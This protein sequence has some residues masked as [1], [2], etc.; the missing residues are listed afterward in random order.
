MAHSLMIN[1]ININFTASTSTLE[2]KNNGSD[3]SGYAFSLESESGNNSIHQYR[4][5]T[6]SGA[7]SLK[8]T[9]NLTKGDSLHIWTKLPKDNG[10]IGDPITDRGTEVIVD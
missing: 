3:V 8:Q 7:T 10:D 4:V 6:S 5:V 9:I 2:G 1:G